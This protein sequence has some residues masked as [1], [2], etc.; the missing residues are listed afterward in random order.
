MPPTTYGTSAQEMSWQDVT[1]P[2]RVSQSAG[3]SSSDSDPTHQPYHA[4]L[5]PESPEQKQNGAL[6][7]N[8]GAY[9]V[10]VQSACAQTEVDIGSSYGQHEMNNRIFNNHLNP[11]YRSKDP[12]KALPTG[13]RA[14]ISRN[15]SL[16]SSDS[17]LSTPAQ[18]NN[19]DTTPRIR[20]PP[21][22]R[23]SQAMDDKPSRISSISLA[24]PQISQAVDDKPSQLASNSLATPKI[25]QAMDDK[26]SRMASGDGLLTKGCAC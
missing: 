3:P 22:L 5:N 6:V 17:D 25:L 19:L 9:A 12:C 1:T 13:P 4:A 23:I 18:L 14:R 8:Q 26:P 10:F 7:P 11:H 16:K 15:P 21:V 2:V 20:L 24:T